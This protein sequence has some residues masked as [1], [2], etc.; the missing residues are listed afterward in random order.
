MQVW[1]YLHFPYL[2]LDALFSSPASLSSQGPSSEQSSLTLPLV[3]V[4]EKKHQIVQLN[5]VAQE[6][7]IKVGMGLGSAAALC[8]DLQVHAYDSDTEHQ[9]LTHIAQW[10]YLKTSD[11]TLY[12][13]K[14]LLLKVTNMLSLY[15]DLDSY[16]QTLYAHITKLNLRFHFA[17]GFSPYSA[18]VLAK[19]AKDTLYRDKEAIMAQLKPHPLAASELEK[20]QV[21]QLS[22][23]G[24]K[25]F[26]ELLALP[27]QDLAKRFNIEL[28]N[29]VGRLLGQF[30]HPVIF[31]HPPEAFN[32]YLELL[33]DIDNV[34]WLEKPL[35]KLLEQLELFLTLRNQVAYELCLTLHLRDHPDQNQ[36]F[37]SAGGDYFAAKWA[38]LSKLSLESIT[39]NAPAHGM[40]LRITRGGERQSH[41]Q[42]IFTGTTARGINAQQTELELISL[43]Q[44]KLG[45]ERICKTQKTHDPRPEKATRLYNPI[46]MPEVHSPLIEPR[47]RPSIMEP[48]PL[49]LYEKV[50]IIDGPERIVSGWWDGDQIT[51]DYFVV[52]SNEGRW[53]WVFRDNKQQ[54][55]LH[56]QFS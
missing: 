28:V 34:L 48:T 13:S 21:E 6:Q 17:T 3:I 15:H 54:W 31:Y 9:T 12:P 19:S 35:M 33:F 23:V 44:A 49:P 55:F 46:S 50:S 8:S 11:I 30:K 18:M 16:W 5:N 4:D 27:L 42:D 45:S 52:R 53:L 24:I 29:Y 2:Q 56:G 22:R 47:L 51:R 26:Q 1:L 14:G 39:L 7:G 10:L 41:T 40:T 32:R 20:K 38:V 36:S 37:T 25:T 43:L